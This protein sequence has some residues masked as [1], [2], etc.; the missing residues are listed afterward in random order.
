MDQGVAAGPAGEHRRILLARP[1]D[2]H[3]LDHADPALV[4]LQAGALDHRA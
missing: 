2:R 3:F 1:L 4:G